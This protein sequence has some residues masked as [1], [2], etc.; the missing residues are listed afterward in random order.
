MVRKS[1]RPGSLSCSRN[2]VLF[3]TRAKSC[4]PL[5]T[6]T[7]KNFYAKKQLLAVTLKKGELKDPEKTELMATGRTYSTPR[8][9]SKDTYCAPS[10][11]VEFCKGPGGAT[12]GRHDAGSYLLD[13]GT[14]Q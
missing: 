14:A 4:S 3:R 10:D 13:R 8:P 12:K 5:Q 9:N 6:N 2:V 11:C 7:T 1:K